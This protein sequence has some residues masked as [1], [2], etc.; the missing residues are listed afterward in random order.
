MTP[1]EPTITDF[2]WKKAL[3]EARKRRAETDTRVKKSIEAFKASET[4][5][6]PSDPEKADS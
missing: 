2:E 4:L 1:K 5:H 3:R 6:L